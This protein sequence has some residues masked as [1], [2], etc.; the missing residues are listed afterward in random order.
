MLPLAETLSVRYPDEV[1]GYYFTGL[2]L[3][4]DGQFINAFAPLTKRSPWTRSRSTARA[5]SCLACDAMRQIVSRYQMPTRC[6]RR[7]ARR[8]AGS[9]C[10][11]GRRCHGTCLADVMS[12]RGRAAEALVALDRAATFDAG[13]REWNDC[14]VVAVHRIYAGDFEQTDRLI[15]GELESGSPFR[16][17]PRRSGIAPSASAIRDGS[18]E[19]IAAA[20][21][22]KWRSTCPR[23]RVGCGSID[24]GAD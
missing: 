12:Q 18:N 7:N 2:G 3:M 13:R 24:G 19:A 1:E 14:S 9:V 10:S 15:A 17:G 21:V 16:V 5:P 11:R 8:A 20:R 4:L 22:E 6:L 23:T